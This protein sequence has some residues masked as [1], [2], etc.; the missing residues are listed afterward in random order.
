[1]LTFKKIWETL[2]FKKWKNIN[3][4]N[5]INM[6]KYEELSKILKCIDLDENNLNFKTQKTVYLIDVSYITVLI[7]N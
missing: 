5:W 2:E 6:K 4:V 3:I 7:V 1:M